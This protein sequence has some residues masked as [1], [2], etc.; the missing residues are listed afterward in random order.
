MSYLEDDLKMALRRAE[1]SEDFTERVLARLHAPARKRN[2]W[3]EFTVLFFPPRLQ[4]VALRVVA[5][6]A[7]P[8]AALQYH[9]E[10]KLR[11]EGAMAKQQLVFAMRVAG[12][13]LHHVQRKVLEM[14][15]TENR[16]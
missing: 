14:T 16:L 2:L 4:W 10:Q 7:I 11:A 13:K 1:P 3:E 9:K 6:I 15:Q 5:S 8:F 12:S